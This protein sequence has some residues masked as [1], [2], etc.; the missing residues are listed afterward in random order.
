MTQFTFT[1][2]YDAY[3]QPRRQVSLAVPRHRDYRARRRQA[4]PTWERSSKAGMPSAMT[5][6]ATS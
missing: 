1:D 6:S 5:R 2:D 3:G 4:R